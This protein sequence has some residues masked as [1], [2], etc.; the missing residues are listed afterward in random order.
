M[1]HDARPISLED[2]NSENDASFY[3]QKLEHSYPKNVEGHDHRIQHQLSSGRQT[4]GSGERSWGLP[5]HLLN[6]HPLRN[7][8]DDR[9]AGESRSEGAP[10]S[11]SSNHI[12]NLKGHEQP[13]V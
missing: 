5:T 10:Q 2:F 6:A 12:W 8:V 9:I 7:A 13:R 1:S 4:I 3:F 11:L